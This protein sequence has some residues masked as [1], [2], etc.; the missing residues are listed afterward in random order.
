MCS[1]ERKRQMISFSRMEFKKDLINRIEEKRQLVDTKF[2]ESINE[3]LIAI[4][5]KKGKEIRK[6]QA[7]KDSQ[8]V[9]KQTLKKA[10]QFA[11]YLS[12]V[13][14]D[15]ELIIMGNYE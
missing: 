5:V 14:F 13:Y 1:E 6:P 10:A 15:S 7:F 12:R 9:G 3:Q 8:K 2:F 11:S 4:L